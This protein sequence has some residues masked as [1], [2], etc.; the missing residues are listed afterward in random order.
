MLHYINKDIIHKHRI[1]NNLLT[2]LCITY[3]LTSQGPKW[4]RNTQ[5]TNN[6]DA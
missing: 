6:I 1:S 5:C 2:R 4:L 3:I